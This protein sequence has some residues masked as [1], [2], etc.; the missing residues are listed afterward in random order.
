MSC[1]RPRAPRSLSGPPS[2][3]TPCPWRDRSPPWP[4]DRVPSKNRLRVARP[5]SRR[6][7]TKPEALSLLPPVRQTLS[8][9]DKA[10]I[11][12]SRSSAGRTSSRD[13]RILAIFSWCA[14]FSR[15]HPKQPMQLSIHLGFRVHRSANRDKS[16]GIGEIARLLAAMLRWPRGCR[17]HRSVPLIQR[18]RAL[19]L[20]STPA[21]H[22]GP[23]RHEAPDDAG[24]P[25]AQL[26]AP[27]LHLSAPSFPCLAS[28][29]GGVPLTRAMNPWA[30]P[31]A[32]T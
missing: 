25:D 14:L 29:V 19:E 27:V 18:N 22:P 30:M 13:R 2:D 5:Q 17:S 24:P 12:C 15:Q 20:R 3:A 1:A 10:G 32:S 16:G 23:H 8:A 11:R 31:E 26:S 9:P 4:R 6:R 7:P 21:R 28:F